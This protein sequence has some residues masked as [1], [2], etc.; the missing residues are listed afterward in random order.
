MKVKTRLAHKLFILI[1]SVLI[2]LMAANAGCK[3]QALPAPTPATTE[4]SSTMVP[5]APFDI[6]VYCKQEKPTLV[7]LSLG[8]EISKISVDSVAFWGVPEQEELDFGLALNMSNKNDASN[9]YAMIKQEK[10]IW[11]KI[12]GNTIYVVY[13]SGTRAKALTTALNN[14]DFKYY[15]DKDALNMAATLPD[16]ETTKITAI[17]I[18]KPTEELIKLLIQDTDNNTAG[19]LNT[20][21]GVGNLKVIMGGLYSSQYI[22]MAELISTFNSKQ[23]ILNLDMGMIISAKSGIPG[24]VVAPV[25]KKVL[26]ETEFTET[27]LGELTVYSRYWDTQGMGIPVLVRIE[28][29]QIYA[30]ISGQESY[31]KTLIT[32]IQP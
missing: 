16:S 8:A 24:I 17:A 4:L 28:G 5:N 3:E 31:A 22:D 29:N 32:N 20:F 2:I 18:A 21:L 1:L 6:Y 10:E 9:I 12:S 13:G 25:V 14:N 11:S 23:N 19:L 15:D 30:A 26:L 7:P 27:K